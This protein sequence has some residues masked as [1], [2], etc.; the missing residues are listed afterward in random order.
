MMTQLLVA[1]LKSNYCMVRNLQGLKIRGL[2]KTALVINFG[3]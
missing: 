3:E 1:T 2:L